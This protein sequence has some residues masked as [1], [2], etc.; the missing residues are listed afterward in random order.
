MTDWAMSKCPL[1]AQA[2]STFLIQAVKL[3]LWNAPWISMPRLMGQKRR[4][5]NRYT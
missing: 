3:F 5:A 1:A 2:S 4:G